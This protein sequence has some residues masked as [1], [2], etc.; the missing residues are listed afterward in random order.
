M[1]L[2]RAG[3]V[4]PTLTIAALALR[5]ADH[6]H[7]KIAPARARKIAVLPRGILGAGR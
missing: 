7:E 3:P 4:E 1:I 6:L 5:L 2:G